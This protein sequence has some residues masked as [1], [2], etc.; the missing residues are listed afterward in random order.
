MCCTLYLCAVIYSCLLYHVF[1]FY[2]LLAVE[3]MVVVDQSISGM[4]Y[5]NKIIYIC[6]YCQFS[7]KRCTALEK[8]P[9]WGVP[10]VLNLIIT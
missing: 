10:T 6:I 5:R 7:N 3:T 9:M 4:H 1:L 8:Y 2:L